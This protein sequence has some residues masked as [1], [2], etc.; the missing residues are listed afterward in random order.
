MR[1]KEIPEEKKKRIKELYGKKPIEE[2]VKTLG[3][4]KPT[5]IKWGKTLT[6]EEKI[7]K[8]NEKKLQASME[9]N[10]I[11]LLEKE[12]ALTKDELIEKVAA[13]QKTCEELIDGLEE[14]GK[15]RIFGERKKAGWRDIITLSTLI[16]LEKGVEKA[17]HLP[18]SVSWKGWGKLISGLNNLSRKVNAL[19]VDQLIK[20]IGEDPNDPNYQMIALKVIK[21]AGWIP[22]QNIFEKVVWI[23]PELKREIQEK[24]ADESFGYP[25]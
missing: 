19:S 21:D 16:G 24:L 5:V 25:P 22:M 15:I 8:L 10:I 13:P 7:V 2:I 6:K 17:T 20:W 9:A 4:S 23:S 1:F 14:A 11:K 12:G 3:V 18:K